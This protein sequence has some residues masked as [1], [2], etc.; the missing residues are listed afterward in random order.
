MTSGDPAQRD[1]APRALTALDGHVALVTGA[2][3]GVGRAHAT[4]LASRGAKV[5]CCDLG[6]EV[7]G[8]GRDT[9]VAE[10]TARAIRDAGGDAVADASDVSTFE[11][12]ASAVAAGVDAFGFVDIVV[13]NAGTASST[14]IEDVTMEAITRQLGVH[15]YGAVG[16]A[17][18]AWPMMKARTWGRVVNTV[19]EAAFPSRVTEGR[20]SGLAYGPAKAA[21]WAATYALAA[22][23]REHGITVNAISPAALTRMNAFMF[24]DAPTGLDLDPMH[25]ARVVAWL[26]S[27]EAG[28]VTGAVIHAAGGHLREY[29]MVR[30]R[31]TELIARLVRALE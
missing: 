22:E 7:D 24:Q 11:G 13:N 14:S 10:A 21:I 6:V 3:R 27:A 15:F 20:G 1:R 5:V 2:G 19:S 28:D 31:D 18:A 29:H 12:G 16:T 9:S 4:L 8:T 25:V 17:K 23:G 26:V 30:D